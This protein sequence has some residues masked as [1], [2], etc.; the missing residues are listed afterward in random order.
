[1]LGVALCWHP[2]VALRRRRRPSLGVRLS[3]YLATCALSLSAGLGW[4]LYPEYRQQVRQRL[5]LEAP[6]LGRAF[7]VKEHIAT[8]ALVLVL[9][10]ALLLTL[11]PR[12]GGESLV[13]A[14][15]RLYGSAAALASVAAIIGIYLSSVY[16]FPYAIE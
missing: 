2:P 16:G 8:F 1:M 13:P 7:E 14:I 9:A 10:G 15:R 4:S 5:Y 6:V 12:P 11:S 3:G